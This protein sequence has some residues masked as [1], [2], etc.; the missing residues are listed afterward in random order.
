VVAASLS[1]A[2]VLT[3]H[4]DSASA[5]TSAPLP[6][7]TGMVLNAPIVDVASTPDGRG[8]WEGASDGGI[9]AFGGA[10][11]YGSTGSHQLNGP[12]VGLQSTP[13]GKGYWE[14]ASDGGVF[15]FGSPLL[16]TG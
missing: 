9:F 3:G 16:G 12:V 1:A 4:A 8:Y 10:N 15:G 5:S 11:F 7:G 6:T 14:V 2:A 13:T